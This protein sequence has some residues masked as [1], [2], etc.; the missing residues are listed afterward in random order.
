MQCSLSA[1]K[2]ETRIDVEFCTWRK[3]LIVFHA[4]VKSSL[5]DDWFSPLVIHSQPS[6]RPAFRHLWSRDRHGLEARSSRLMLYRTVGHAESD[7]WNR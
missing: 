4:E 5:S 7:S 6:I 2:K 1:N 3:D